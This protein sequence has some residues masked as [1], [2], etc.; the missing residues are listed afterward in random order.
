MKKWRR[1]RLQQPQALSSSCSGL[2]LLWVR[3]GAELGDF[4]AHK[5][6]HGRCIH[7]KLQA[8]S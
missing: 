3:R 7:T 2:L 4:G 6:A 8:L 5:A 1:R